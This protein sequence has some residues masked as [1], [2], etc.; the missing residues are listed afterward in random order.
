MDTL[1]VIFASLLVLAGSSVALAED[2]PKPT[3]PDLFR[4]EPRIEIRP[5]GRQDG[6]YEVFKGWE[7]QGR[8]VPDGTGAYRFWPDMAKPTYDRVPGVT[9]PR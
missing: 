9:T 6:S 8:M 4:H 2:R 5:S 3:V 7:Y 1:R